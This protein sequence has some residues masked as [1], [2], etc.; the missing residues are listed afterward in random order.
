MHVQTRGKEFPLPNDLTSRLMDRVNLKNCKQELQPVE[1]PQSELNSKKTKFAT[2]IFIFDYK[3]I[4]MVFKY[5]GE[6]Q[7]IQIYLRKHCSITRLTFI[8][9]GK[10]RTRNSLCKDLQIHLISPSVHTQNNY[11]PIFTDFIAHHQVTDIIIHLQCLSIRSI[12]I[13]SNDLEE[14]HRKT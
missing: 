11:S 9:K 5:S 8:L 2:G 3:N 7:I 10:T 4:I 1:P 6:T 14:A 12:F 13:P